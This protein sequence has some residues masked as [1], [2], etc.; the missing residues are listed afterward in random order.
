[1]DRTNNFSGKLPVNRDSLP[2][3]DDKSTNKRK[4][5]FT[6]DDGKVDLP[7]PSIS[8]RP[9]QLIRKTASGVPYGQQNSGNANESR[10]MSKRA[11]FQAS[12]VSAKE[13]GLRTHARMSSADLL[14]SYPVLTNVRS[15]Q[16]AKRAAGL[17]ANVRP[18]LSGAGVHQS[19]PSLR[20]EGTAL[21]VTLYGKADLLELVAI[22][23]RDPELTAVKIDG[24]FG[25]SSGSKYID[26]GIIFALL[27]GGEHGAIEPLDDACFR[28]L[29]SSLNQIRSLD[30]SG[31]RLTAQNFVDLATFI[32]KDTGLQTLSLG[33]GDVISLDSQEA[34]GAAL[35]ANST[36]RELV[37]DKMVLEF[38]MP[39]IFLAGTLFR[40]IPDQPLIA[41]IQ[42]N[43]SLRSVKLS[44][45]SHSFLI[46]PVFSLE[47]AAGLFGQGS[48]LHEISFAGTELGAVEKSAANDD[49]LSD[50]LATSGLHYFSMALGEP[51]SK[52]EL[53]FSFGKHLEVLDLSGCSLTQKQTHHLVS[54][55]PFGSS[56]TVLN[57]DENK[58][59]VADADELQHK[60]LKN[61]PRLSEDGTNAYQQL[62]SN[63]VNAPQYWPRELSMTLAMHTPIADLVSLS[64]VWAD[65]QRRSASSS[66]TRLTTAN[67]TATTTAS[68]TSPLTTTTTT[69]TTTIAEP[70]QRGPSRT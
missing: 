41:G 37:L 47:Q 67:G 61:G 59:Q 24:H 27:S 19:L 26:P 55:L 36:L 4:E 56:L 38:S 60:L 58:I 66:A 18:P 65:M 17:D 25:G 62:I 9:A 44:H 1:M 54:S 68:A 69:T 34:L 23:A 32:Q 53:P 43:Q 45:M 52:K 14:S 15:D 28:T 6:P 48:R 12:L 13:P 49:A 64:D 8:N 46:G 70:G 42:A 50:Y 29:L 16:A 51:G 20:K 31:C 3:V 57:L 30:L 7:S 33:N 10:A 35:A 21:R 63:S 2:P 39:R 40:S 5:K 22:L 11:A